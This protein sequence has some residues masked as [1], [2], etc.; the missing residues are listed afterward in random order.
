MIALIDEFVEVQLDNTGYFYTTCI[1]FGASVLMIGE[2]KREVRVLLARLWDILILCGCYYP[3][4]FLLYSVVPGMWYQMVSELIL[5]AVYGQLMGKR[6]RMEQLVQQVSFFACFILLLRVSE[7]ISFFADQVGFNY[8]F[9]LSGA[10]VVMLFSL[11]AVALYLRHFHTDRAQLLPGLYPVLIIA[12]C[13]V[14]VATQLYDMM[15]VS[16]S[17][18]SDTS[19]RIYY[20]LLGLSF[21]ALILM[22]YYLYYAIGQEHSDKLQLLV[23]KRKAELDEENAIVMQKTY[24]ALREMRHEL[25]NHMAYMNTLLD[26]GDYDGLRAYF[27]SY[28]ANAAEAIHYVHCGNPIVDAVV[29]NCISRAKLYDIKVEPVLAVPAQLPYE[30]GKL[31]SLLA[32]LVDN[33]IEATAESGAAVK[34]IYFSIRPQQD[35][36][37]IRVQNPVDTKNISVRR[38]LTL[39]TTKQTPELHGYGTRIIRRIAE[40]YDGTATFSIKDGTFIADVMLAN[41]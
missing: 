6:A 14:A 9:V 32:N 35:Y 12:M 37:L 33:A 8:F 4:A 34:K 19:T 41:R 16:P 31:C 5:F 38:R 10:N 11:T 21:L 26:A 13:A 1:F 17:T 20:L 27:Q 40:E 2:W 22:G 25:K 36:Y 3:L 23:G 29:N 39:Q 30:D 24:E 18:I 15:R 28:Q 7:T